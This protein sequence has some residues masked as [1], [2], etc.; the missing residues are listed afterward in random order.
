M[1]RFDERNIELDEKNTF[2]NSR[3][4]VNPENKHVIDYTQILNQ[5]IHNDNNDK[6]KKDTLINETKANSSYNESQKQFNQLKET[7]QMNFYDKNESDDSNNDINDRENE[8]LDLKLRVKNENKF[9]FAT[10]IRNSGFWGKV[11]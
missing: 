7:K 10:K 4:N 9:H 3:F 8:D 1:N 11:C 5:N 6:R 2:E